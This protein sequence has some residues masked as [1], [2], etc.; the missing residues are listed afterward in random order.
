MPDF[1]LP[2]L[3]EDIQEADVLKVLVSEGDMVEVDQPIL[4][5]E[6]EKAT[7]DVP[8]E[9]AG[10]VTKVHVSAGETINIGQVIVTIESGESGTADAS[11]TAAK[12]SD[13]LSE[14]EQPAASDGEEKGN[15]REDAD[16]DD[17]PAEPDTEG[18]EEPSPAVADADGT[19]ETTEA[20]DGASAAP[21]RR[22]APAARAAS[23]ETAAP[24]QGTVFASPQVRPRGRRRPRECRGERA[25]R[26]HHRRRHQACRSRACRIAAIAAI[27]CIGSTGRQW[28]GPERP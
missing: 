11:G 18:E 17:A 5:I 3:G 1:K 23:T 13:T 14:E 16:T 2:S 21:P 26:A 19:E 28:C 7:L 25:G 6:T 15:A 12:P 27:G 22:E 20:A 24:G 8:A 4:E 10:T 9:A